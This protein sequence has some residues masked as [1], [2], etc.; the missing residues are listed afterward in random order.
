MLPACLPSL[1]SMLLRSTSPTAA[2][3]AAAVPAANAARLITTGSGLLQDP[4]LISSVSRTGSSSELL[5]GP[6]AYVLVLLA[7]T[8][9]AWREHPAGL[10]AV[11]MMCG[12]DGLADIV[13]RRW[14]RQLPLPWNKDKSWP[15]SAA[16]LL[17]GV[18][19]C[20]G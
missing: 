15:G 7:A 11:S 10:I 12:G 4:K 1:L 13:G 5:K 20:I 3:V 18:A 19:A 17:G 6:L 2:A 16:M 8:L 14:G 9:F